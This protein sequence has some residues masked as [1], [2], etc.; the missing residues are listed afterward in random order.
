VLKSSVPS[1]IVEP[2][3]ISNPTERAMLIKPE[4]IQ[5]VAQAIATALEAW[6]K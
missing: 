5:A 2:G 4:S 1:I 3:F 6:K